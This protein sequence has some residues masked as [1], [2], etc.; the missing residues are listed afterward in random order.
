MINKYKGLEV[1][2]YNN[3]MKDVVTLYKN[4]KGFIATVVCGEV[5]L[6]DP[7]GSLMYGATNEDEAIKLLLKWAD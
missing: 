5:T 3:S 7:N 6:Y 2:T 1:S 4:N